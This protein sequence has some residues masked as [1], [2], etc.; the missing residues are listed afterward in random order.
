M[1]AG[2]ERGGAGRAERQAD[3][4]GGE[5]LGGERAERGAELAAEEAPP[6]EV[7]IAAIGPSWARI[8]S[9]TRSPIAPT[10]RPATGS[11]SFARRRGC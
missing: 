3:V 2:I 10:I 9:G 6:S 4:A 7:S 5:H 11:H 1:L 8:S